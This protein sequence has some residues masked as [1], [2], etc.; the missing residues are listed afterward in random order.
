MKTIITEM[1][2]TLGGINSILDVAED[3][4]SDLEDK[5][6]ENNQSEKK[7]ENRLR[8]RSPTPRLQTSTSL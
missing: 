4:I 7:N 6:A 5:V 2:N 3:Q 8:Q 1:K